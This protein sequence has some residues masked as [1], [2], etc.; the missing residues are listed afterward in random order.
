LTQH[1]LQI[2]L[3]ALDHGRGSWRGE[4][5]LWGGDTLTGWYAGADARSRGTMLLVL[6]GEVAEGRWVGVSGAGAI[7]TGHAALA[8]TREEAQRTI[9]LIAAGRRHLTAKVKFSP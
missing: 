9:T 2:E 1:G 4:L 5:R 7:V 8:R 6:R 3:E